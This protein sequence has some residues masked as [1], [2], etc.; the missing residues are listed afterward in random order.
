MRVAR[1]RGLPRSR[2]KD[3]L[4]KVETTE[5]VDE[6]YKALMENIHRTDEK[7]HRAILSLL[8]STTIF[9]LLAHASIAEASLGPFKLSN[10]PLLQKYIPLLAAYS[11][12][13]DKFVGNDAQIYAR[14]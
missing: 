7:F 5:Y 13:L 9:E 8:F 14:H 11:Y 3:S 1:I 12:L 6:Y 10:L 4:A 2:I